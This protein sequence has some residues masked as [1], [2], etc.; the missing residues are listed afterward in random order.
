MCGICGSYDPAGVTVET[1]R[2]M[3]QAIAHRGPD[4]EGTFVNGRIGLG[5]RRLSI[6][7]LAGGHQPISNED[8]TV[9]VV[10]N[11]EIYNYRD[12]RREM[13]DKGHTLRTQSDTEVLVHLYEEMG[14]SLVKRLRG[15]FAFAL[16]D[17]RQQKLLLGRDHLGQKPLFYAQDGTQFLFASEIKSILAA[18]QR[19]RRLNFEAVHHYLSL[20]FV[21]PPQTMLQGIH[22]LPPAHILVLQ[23]GKVSISRYWELS[24]HE[25]LVL[26]ERD[27]IERLR[28]ELRSAVESHLIS[29]VPVGA[30]LSGGMDSSMIVAIMAQELDASIDTFAI[31]VSQQEFNELPYARAVANHHHTRH[32]E[33]CVEFDLVASL[34]D[35]IWHLDEPS[36]PI[37]ACQYQAAALAARHVK[38]VLGG[39]GGDELFAG[40]DRYV[41][42]GYVGNYARI[43][44]AI[45]RHLI[46]GLL[47]HVPE[48]FAY[49]S[50]SQKLRWLQQL[51]Q[52]PTLAERY[53]E[54][55]CFFRFN[56][57]QKEELFQPDWWQQ[58]G[59]LDSTAVITD[60]FNQAP[61]DDPI[62]RMLY[63]DYQTRLPEHS[64]ML[65]DRMT[66]AHGLE[67]RSPFLDHELVEMMASFP[68]ETKIKGRQLKYILRQLGRDYLP[69]EILN[70]G[71]QGFMFPVAY[72]FRNELYD[73]LCNYLL[74]SHFITEGIFQRQTVVKLLEEHQ[75]NRVDH[76]V[77]LW[78]LL[79]LAVWHELYIA[80]KDKETVRAELI[81]HLPARQRQ[82]L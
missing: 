31:G 69:E 47:A 33:E 57:R 34:P 10:L 72:W 38:V 81:Q 24:F 64:L 67:L 70:R 35:M 27:Y 71:K 52:L 12:L 63:A 60:P 51:A 14:E 61:A 79:N 23:G 6:I 28:G 41:G 40:F 13:E 56:H 55:T 21:P 68:V 2:P 15:M 43:P 65:T 66:M 58:V 19:P 17:E 5:N 8:G 29:D 42:V 62:D 25:K 75:Q 53:A 80:Q 7:D 74:G 44:E 37:A 82:P 45:R 77:R 32:W 16:W 50:A 11:G 76:H 54:A 30:F 22:K 4:D 48:N 46:G 9:T 1:L 36:D 3:M 78:M 26:S 49:K 39:D 73:F 59:H 18:S 20:R